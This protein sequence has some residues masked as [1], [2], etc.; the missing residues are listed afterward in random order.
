MI[1][2]KDFVFLSGNIY[3]KAR[4]FIFIIMENPFKTPLAAE[5]RPVL[6][7]VLCIL[8]FIGSGWSVLSNLFSIFTVEFA[9]SNLQI[10]QYSTM[11]NNLEGNGT[12][13]FWADLLHSCMEFFTAMALHARELAIVHLVLNLVSL[14]GAILMFQLRRLGF[15]LYVT[16]QI[17]IVLVFP[18]FAGFSFIVFFLMFFAGIISLIFIILYACT[19]KYMR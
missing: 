17:L 12:S 14:L 11:V 4:T 3:R 18:Y 1:Y 8:T 9:N 7:L 13:V 15:Y 19:L 2:Y 5:Q 10:E 16:A 6:L